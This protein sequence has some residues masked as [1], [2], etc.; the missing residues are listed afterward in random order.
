V[1]GGGRGELSDSPARHTR[2]SEPWFAGTCRRAIATI[3]AMA[4]V[5]RTWIGRRATAS[6]RS[7]RVH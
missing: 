3:L 5:R 6:V 4:A 2:R 1:L 7:S